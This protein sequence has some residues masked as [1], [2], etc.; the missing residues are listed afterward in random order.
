MNAV[1]LC[2]ASFALWRDAGHRA[3]AARLLAAISFIRSPCFCKS[4]CSCARRLLQYVKM[5]HKCMQRNVTTCNC[6][7]Q[8]LQCL[9]SCHRHYIKGLSVNAVPLR[10]APF[11][12][13][14]DAGHRAAGARLFAAISFIHSPCFCNSSCSCARRLLQ[15]FKM[16]QKCMQRNVTTCNSAAQLLQCLISCHRH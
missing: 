8:L 1:P 7:A 11:A 5:P 6:A 14:R 4:S 16:P 9:M 2:S 12:L 13:W 10:S 3:A 15:Y